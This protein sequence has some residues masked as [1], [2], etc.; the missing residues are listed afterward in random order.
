MN[1]PWPS[2]LSTFPRANKMI[3]NSFNGILFIM[4]QNEI[5]LDNLNMAFQLSGFLIELKIKYYCKLFPDKSK[6]EVSRI[7]Y[8]E[9]VDY[10]E[11]ELIN[12]VQQ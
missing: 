3:K 11:K 7:V 1:Q 8:K 10:K 5:Y 12:A 2:S 9:L 6:D 4:N